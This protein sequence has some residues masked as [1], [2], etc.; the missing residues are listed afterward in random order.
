M[1]D[2]VSGHLVFR[3]ISH[4]FPLPCLGE[5]GSRL[6]ARTVESL[7]MWKADA[8]GQ[9]THRFIA[10]EDK[11]EVPPEEAKLPGVQPSTRWIFLFPG[12]RGRR[13][14]NDP[15]FYFVIKAASAKLP[16]QDPYDTDF[17]LLPHARGRFFSGFRNG[18]FRNH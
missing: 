14:V 8:K 11:A 6:A 17:L 1:D 2:P 18:R 13:S 5:T 7:S 9:L 15:G 12:N 16:P 10:V 3:G 4:A